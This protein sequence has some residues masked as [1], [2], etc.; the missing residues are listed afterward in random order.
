MKNLI[1]KLLF[2]S[3]L[4]SLEKSFA[5]SQISVTMRIKGEN[6]KKVTD[7]SNS[8]NL[9]IVLKN[10]QNFPMTV[11]VRSALTNTAGLNIQNK[12]A[13][14]PSNAIALGANATYILSNTDLQEIFNTNSS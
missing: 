9:T 7:L 12:S 13:F 3:A 4:F 6:I 8:R 11:T 1:L 14:K 5:Q 2:I 10:N